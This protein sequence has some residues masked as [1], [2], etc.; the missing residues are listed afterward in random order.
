MISGM[1][2][3]LNLRGRPRGVRAGA[4]R[5]ARRL[6]GR[7]EYNKPARARKQRRPRPHAK[8]GGAPPFKESA[9]PAAVRPTPAY[10]VT[11][12]VTVSDSAATSLPQKRWRRVS[13]YRP[14]SSR[15]Y[16]SSRRNLWTRVGTLGSSL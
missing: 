5:E 15:S 16:Q 6:P 8:A 7:A 4:P 3:M 10:G 14:G 13:S 12:N 2:R 11:S 9:P 1:E